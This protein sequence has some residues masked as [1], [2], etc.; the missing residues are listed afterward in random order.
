MDESASHARSDSELAAA[1]RSFYDV[2]WGGARLIEPA[3]FNTWPLAS[4]L[5]A[6]SRRSLEVA[7][8]LR[9]RLPL[10]GT[11]FLDISKAAISRFRL[12]GATAMVGLINALPFADASFDLLCTFDIVEHVDDD[13]TALAELSRV[14]AP[15]AVLLLSVPLHEAAWTAFD[16]FVGHRRRYEP[17]A[18][19]DKLR[20]HGFVI[21]RSAVFG[22]QPKSSRLV[23]LG[24]WFLTHRRERAMWWYNRVFMPLG[25]RMQKNLDWKPGLTDQPDID[26]T[27]LVCRKQA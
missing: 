17:R 4:Q 5:A 16:D 6:H 21:E 18:L 12:R 22:M 27:L 10:E 3:R 20:R 11:L 2:L 19:Q 7:P 1:N 8:G 26:T 13:E 24:M 23:D 9:P 14:A 15:G 25:L